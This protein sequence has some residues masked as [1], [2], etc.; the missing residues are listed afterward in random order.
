[1][2]KQ[3]LLLI[4]AVF[5]TLCLVNAQYNY[6]SIPDSMKKNADYI[7]WEDYEEFKVINLG[8]AVEHIKFA[9]LITDKYARRYEKIHIG[10]SKDMKL[11]SFSGEIYDASGKR[12]K[13]LKKEDIVDVSA[14]SGGTMYSDTRQKILDFSYH[15]YPYT[16]VYEYERARNGILGYPIHIFQKG[17]K[18]GVISSTLKFILPSD[19]KFKHKAYN[20]SNAVST[21]HVKNNNIHIWTESNI[22]AKEYNDLSPS[23]TYFLQGV[24]LAPLK[25]HMGGYFGSM[26]SWESLSSWNYKLNKGRDILSAES[27]DKIKELVKDVDGDREKAKILYEYMQNKTRYVSIS[28]G[29]GG[30]QPFP[31]KYVDKNGYGDCKALSNYMYSMLKV[32]GVKSHYVLVKSG[33]GGSDIITEFVNDQFNHIILC[34]PQEKDTIWLECTNQQIPFGYLGSGT[35]DRHVLLV[36]EVGGKLVKTPAYG[37]DVNTQIRNTKIN[38]DA[39]GDAAITVNTILGGISFEDRFGIEEYSVKDQKKYLHKIY[40]ISGMLLKSFNYDVDK[41][42]IPSITEN[43]EMNIPKLASVSSK[44][45]FLKMNLFNSGVY[46]PEKNLDRKIPFEIKRGY[47]EIDSVQINTPEGYDVESLPSEKNYNTK[48]GS[49]STK[50]KVEE[51]NILFVRKFIV[52]KGISPA[53]EY[54]NFYNF[55]KKIKKADKAKLVLVKK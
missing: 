49:Y 44:R 15:T 50:I 21:S 53:S 42:E 36:D 20:L 22:V 34:I 27:S 25:F 4:S 32:S 16:I 24:V 35:D 19:M 28:R 40:D 31:A 47:T 1:M 39:K 43:I 8:K 7:V 37:K 18:T 45:M 3:F 29:I 26:D 55:R 5:Y 11:N 9:V 13:K 30:I 38:V 46:V 14:I 6:S 48:F 33:D 2:K 23:W 41:S 10:Y 12:V 51:Q 52:E 17:F 54:M